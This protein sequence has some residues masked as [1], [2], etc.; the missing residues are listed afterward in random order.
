MQV[1]A[2]YTKKKNNRDVRFLRRAV[3]HC[4]Y[5]TIPMLLNM[6]IFS[7]IEVIFC[8]NMGMAMG[9]SFSA[10]AFPIYQKKEKK[11]GIVGGIRFES[12]LLICTTE[13]CFSLFVSTS[14]FSRNQKKKIEN[15]IYSYCMNASN[16]NLSSI[17]RKSS[18]KKF[19]SE[20]RN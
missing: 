7:C 16:P 12:N 14:K 20:T 4:M 9:I 2:D 13:N 6:A 8:W 5:V 11:E 15:F 19:Q 17:G 3:L 1:S 18:D 10:N